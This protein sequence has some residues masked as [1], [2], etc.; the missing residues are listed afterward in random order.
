[1]PKTLIAG[2]DVIDTADGARVL[3]GTDVLI[4]GDTIA[5]VGPGLDAFDAEVL[6]AKGCLVLPGFVDTHRHTWQT[7]L[8]GLM[9][10]GTLAEY[11][12]RVLNVVGPRYRPADVY[13]GTLAGALEC[14]DAG[15]T[16]LVDWAHVQN[17]PDHGDASVAALRDSGIRAVFAHSFGLPLAEPAPHPADARR[18][19]QTH[20]PTDSGLVSMAL[21][22]RGPQYG[23]AG[24]A[25]DDIRLARD[26]GCRVTVHVHTDDAVRALHDHGVLGDD[27]TFVHGDHL[28]DTAAVLIAESGGTASV[29]PPI[30]AHLSMGVAN[31][32]R[33]LR[34]GITVGLS[35][36]SVLASA[37]DMFTQMRGA[38]SNL[39]LAGAGAGAPEVLRMATMDGATVAGLGDRT[40]SVTVGKQADIVLLRRDTLGMRPANDPVSAVVMCADKSDVDTVM[41]AG[42]I[43]KRHGRLCHDGLS[44]ALRLLDETVGHLDASVRTSAAGAGRAE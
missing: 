35:A 33:L 10:T 12:R 25:A 41:V 28:G 14:L 15:I 31:L 19:R 24:I 11:R 26:L 8:R 6:D 9:A 40:G 29:S 34:H 7:P 5:A 42:R 4:D 43:V 3:P 13:A 20:L 32:A 18:I 38:L 21:G 27:I 44:R 37:G 22:I 17:T 23:P 1:M 16:T 30:E 36:D 39:C 2:G